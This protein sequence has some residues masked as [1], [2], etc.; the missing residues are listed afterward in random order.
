MLVGYIY[1]VTCFV[2]ENGAN[3]RNPNFVVTTPNGNRMV[4][5]VKKFYDGNGRV[6]V[7]HFILTPFVV[8][9]DWMSRRN[10][11]SERS[12]RVTQQRQRMNDLLPVE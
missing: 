12:R 2:D 7:K 10:D 9:E 4:I 5:G 11:A 3:L 6:A 1:C 8:D